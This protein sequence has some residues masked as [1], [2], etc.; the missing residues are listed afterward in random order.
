MTGYIIQ[1]GENDIFA[2]TYL[3]YTPNNG[4]DLTNRF[5]ATVFT[6]QQLEDNR[7]LNDYLKDKKYKIYEKEL[8]GYDTSLYRYRDR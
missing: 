7:R 4:F 3:R 1:I 2:K 6:K 8:I 5:V